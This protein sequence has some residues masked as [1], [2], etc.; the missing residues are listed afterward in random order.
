[1]DIAARFDG[2]GTLLRSLDEIVL[3]AGGRHYLAKDA[4]MGPETLSRGYPRLEEWKS[5]KN[6]V[7]PDGIWSSDLARRLELSK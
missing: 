4:H 2:L 5:V 6:R 7:D 1:V 3:A